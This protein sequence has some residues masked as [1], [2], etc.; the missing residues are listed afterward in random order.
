[1]KISSIGGSRYTIINLNGKVVGS[2]G[3][4]LDTGTWV[5]DLN[6]NLYRFQNFKDAK[7]FVKG[8]G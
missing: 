2:I 7:S 1:M 5:V 3:K 6:H 4:R 8:K